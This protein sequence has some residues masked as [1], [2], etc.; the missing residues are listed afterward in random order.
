MSSVKPGS[1]RSFDLAQVVD[2]GLAVVDER[3]GAALSIRAVAGRLGVNPNSI[4]T[5]V[6]SRA[7]LEHEIIERVVGETDVNILFDESRPW[8]ER[9]IDYGLS[10][11]AT[12]HA[13]PAAALLMASSRADGPHANRVGEGLLTALGDTGLSVDDSA[14]AAHAILVQLIG[15]IAFEI[16]ETATTLPL[17]N[18]KTR[19]ATRRKLLEDVEDA[20]RTTEAADT[21]ASWISAEQ[22]TWGLRTLL[23]GLRLPTEEGH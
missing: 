15:S 5:Y 19:I 7:V 22:F 13:H 18:E 17:P 10:M 23:R 4:Y 20:P 11:R 3:G 12:F 1:R 8:D 21:I 16:A 2:A 6:N 14:R 9:I